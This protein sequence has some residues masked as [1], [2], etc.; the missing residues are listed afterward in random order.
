MQ[1]PRRMQRRVLNVDSGVRKC[2]LAKPP[3][4]EENIPGTVGR[5]NVPSPRT[6][7]RLAVFSSTVAAPAL[8][9][10]S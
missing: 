5:P 6:A 1:G 2:F 9:S 8:G 7:R 3:T 10:P 4:G